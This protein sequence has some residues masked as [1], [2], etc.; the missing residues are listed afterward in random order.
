M[1]IANVS[2]DLNVVI[3]KAIVIFLKEIDAQSV[4]LGLSLENYYLRLK[5]P[6]EC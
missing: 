3:M 6:Q 4:N 5:G 1:D 2:F